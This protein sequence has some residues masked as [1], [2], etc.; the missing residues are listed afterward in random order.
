MIL[1]RPKALFMDNKY[2]PGCGHGVVNRLL[3]EVLEESGE[4]KTAIGAIAV[5][6]SSLMPETFGMD[7]VQA[8]HGRATA[9]ACGIKR[10]RPE[11]TVFTYQGD[12]DALAIGLSE[13]MWTAI[14]NENITVI[15]VN[16]GTFGMTGGQMA[17]TTLSGQKTTTSPIGRNCDITGNPLNIIEIF[18]NLDVAYLSRCMVTDSANILK[19]K[20][21]IK[22]AFDMQREKKGFSFVEILA[23]CPTNWKLS[24]V[25][26]LKHIETSVQEVYP[27]CEYKMWEERN[28]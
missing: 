2:C 25:D 11:C 14:R 3:A 10:A 21:C 7:V 16:N 6:C 23:P 4:D 17:P 12:G 8:Q 15:F 18:K 19:T 28:G 24:P 27:L 9:V 22:K 1:K 13:T 26:S 5:G 20:R